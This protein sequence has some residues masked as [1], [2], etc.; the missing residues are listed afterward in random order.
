MTVSAPVTASSSERPNEGSS[1][2]GRGSGSPTARAPQL[3]QASRS[4]G[5][6]DLADL[7]PQ[8]GH[9]VTLVLDLEYWKQFSMNTVGFIVIHEPAAVRF[10]VQARH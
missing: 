9:I 2:S 3:G 7:N 10:V 4:V 1:R 5:R 6:S 8:Q